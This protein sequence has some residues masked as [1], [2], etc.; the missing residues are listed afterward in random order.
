MAA[1]FVQS[2]CV[3][4]AGVDVPGVDV[5]GVDVAGA[6]VAGAD[7]AGFAVAVMWVVSWLAVGG[8]V[9]RRRRAAPEPGIKLLGRWERGQCTKVQVLRCPIGTS[10]PE[11][12]Q[13][14]V[15]RSLR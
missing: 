1:G 2:G 14:L 5:A 13:A 12:R 7:G 10:P 11:R 15:W 4:V 9:T 3:D 6:E 8:G